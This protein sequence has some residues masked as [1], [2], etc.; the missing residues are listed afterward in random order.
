MRQIKN[1]GARLTERAPGTTTVDVR[2]SAARTSPGRSTGMSARTAGAA[3][4]GAAANAAS[5]R[6]D[7]DPAGDGGRAVVTLSPAAAGAARRLAS[8]MGNRTSLPE[9]V[10]RG[11]ML[12]D[13]Y[14][15]LP[16]SE[17]LVIRNRVTGEVERIRFTWDTC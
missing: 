6:R 3:I 17:E 5:S 11:L 2:G 16:D 7:P 10:R 4:D 1:A 14:L 8:K 13:V 9:V 15:N 12:L